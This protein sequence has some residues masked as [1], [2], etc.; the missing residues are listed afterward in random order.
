MI[1][2]NFFYKGFYE[3]Y[4][5]LKETQDEDDF[6]SFLFMENICESFDSDDLSS[7]D[8]YKYIHGYCDEFAMMLS[9]LYRYEIKMAFCGEV[10]IHAWC[11]KGKYFIDARGITDDEKLF[12]S[13]YNMKNTTIYT[14]ANVEEFLQFAREMLERQNAKFDIVYEKEL[15]KFE[16]DSYMKY[17]YKI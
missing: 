13:E 4:F 9:K 17:Y 10:L 1:I 2:N 7:V 15:K 5:N 6:E 16:N 14:V 11:Q 3:D 12:F 8:L